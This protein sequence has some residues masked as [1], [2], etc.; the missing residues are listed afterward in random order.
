LVVALL[1]FLT[2]GLLA[3][4]SAAPAN[5]VLRDLRGRPQSLE[6]LRGKI[7][8]LNV[9]ATWCEGCRE[10][11]PLLVSLRNRYKARGVEMVAASVDD[12]TTQHQIKPFLR[13]LKV[14]FP[15][16]VGAGPD[17]MLDLG[18]GKVLPATAVIDRAGR[19]QG[20]ILGVVEKADLEHRIEYL[21]GM[22]EGPPPAPVLNNLDLPARK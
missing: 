19:I 21:L 6:K 22:R 3:A 1:G 7:V 12:E 10:E 14:S 16:W 17:H 13:K 5:L 11:M 4:Q 15:V 20:R 2:A 18:L 8:V 9:W